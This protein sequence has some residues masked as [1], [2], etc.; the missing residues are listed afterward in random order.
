MEYRSE[1][2]QWLDEI[3]GRKPRL[4]WLQSALWGAIAG[5]LIALAYGLYV[6][7][8]SGV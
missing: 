6:L 4:D 3:E 5:G 2:R 1:Y 8:R 7:Q